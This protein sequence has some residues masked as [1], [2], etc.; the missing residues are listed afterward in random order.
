MKYKDVK[1]TVLRTMEN[2]SKG[3]GDGFCLCR[4]TEWDVD[5]DFGM[6]AKKRKYERKVK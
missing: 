5:D 6:I 3:V 4:I 1:I 2:R